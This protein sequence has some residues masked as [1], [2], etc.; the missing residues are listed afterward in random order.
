MTVVKRVQDVVRQP[1]MVQVLSKGGYD[2]ILVLAHMD[3]TDPLVEVILNAIRHVVGQDM[4]IQFVTGH[5]HR[6]AYA[7][8][9]DRATSF[10]AGRYL[11]TVG[12]VSF[13][14]METAMRERQ[15]Q[16]SPSSS[17]GPP[18]PAS[19]SNSPPLF[20]YQYVDAN[21][22]TLQNVLR[23]TVHGVETVATGT[24]IEEDVEDR[25]QGNRSS[26]ALMLPWFGTPRGIELS[27]LIHETQHRLGLDR[28][29]GCSRETY[30]QLSV[31][32]F[33]SEKSLWR[34]YLDQ[35]IPTQLFDKIDD[36][37]DDDDG[38]GGI[39]GKRR[40]FVQ[41]TGAFRYDLFR[42]EVTLDDVIAVCP[43]NDSIFKLTDSMYGWQILE[44]LEEMQVQYGRGPVVGATNT[45]TASHPTPTIPAF[46]T[47]PAIE[48]IDPRQSYALYVPDFEFYRMV[49]ILTKILTRDRDADMD[50]V[51]GTAGIGPYRTN[52]S[53]PSV[54][55]RRPVCYRRKQEGTVMD[56]QCLYTT[57]L[58]KTYVVEE[59]PCLQSRHYDHSQ[60]ENSFLRRASGTVLS[61]SRHQDVMDIGVY[62]PSGQDARSTIAGTDEG[63][64][65]LR[66]VTGG[67]VCLSLV[68]A[69]L[70]VGT[71]SGFF[72][73]RGIAV[74]F[75]R[76]GPRQGRFDLRRHR[77]EQEQEPEE[78]KQ[79]LFFGA[80]M[81]K[82]CHYK[83]CS[84]HQHRH[85]QQHRPTSDSTISA[86]Q[87]CGVDDTTLYGS[88]SM[89]MSKHNDG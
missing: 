11:D 31:P 60:E 50:D 63:S 21:Q 83:E 32:F 80:L 70:L 89:S 82:G 17:S 78:E 58:W 57:D 68:V 46:A 56:D 71:I 30:H 22:R 77:Q 84:D 75:Y 25:Y 55:T 47:A 67:H 15:Q 39:G 59:M 51:V 48:D 2:A 1:W 37:D 76:R 13:P 79:P 38:D 72:F 4:P 41:G 49:P 54:I 5:T 16:R 35:V 24:E 40:I 88:I 43:F 10:E 44:T 34:L 52:K 27:R 69:A 65:Y 14:T 66:L 9:D 53:E 6:R 23:A 19:P 45:S 8:L 3:C 33:G 20:R 7:V 36:D 74:S 18:P 61:G 85:Q 29:L 64:H 42:G 73:T 81:R 86:T 12:F 62:Y 87:S 28:V 26:D